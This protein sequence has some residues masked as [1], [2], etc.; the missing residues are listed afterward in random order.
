MMQRIGTIALPL[1]LFTAHVL[2]QS[3][4]QLGGSIQG[5]VF[6]T[7]QDHQRSVVPATKL[8]LDGPTHRETQSDP[9]GKFTFDA[10]S[11]QKRPV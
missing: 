2:G 7:E 1:G 4:P 10:R 8:S 6:T 9:E 3:K 5:V 11:Q